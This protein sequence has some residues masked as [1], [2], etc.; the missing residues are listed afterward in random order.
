MA[1]KKTQV[2]YRDFTRG[3]ITEANPL[4]FP[5]NASLDEQNMNINRDGSRQRR[6]GMDWSDAAHEIALADSLSS[7]GDAV[8]SFSWKSVGNNGEVNLGVV[9]RGLKLYFYDLNLPDPS[10]SLLYTHTFTPLE[11]PSAA[12][13]IHFSSAYGKLIMAVGTQIVYVGTWNG[14]SLDTPLDSYSLEVR[15]RWGVD[16]G[17]A[18]DFRPPTLSVAHE[19]N[20]RNQGWPLVTWVVNP[21]GDGSVAPSYLD[22]LATTPANFFIITGAL[23]YPSNADLF[24]AAKMAVILPTSTQVNNINAHSTWELSKLNFGTTPAPRGHYIID[25]FSRGASRIAVSGIIGLPADQSFGYVNSV[26]SYA[27]RIWHSVVSTIGTQLGDFSPNIGNMLFYSIASS[28]ID[29]W[30]K[31]HAEGDPSSEESNDPIDT[32]GGFVTLTEAG[33]IFKMIPMGESLFVFA[34]NGVWEIFGGDQGFSATIQSVVKVTDIGPLSEKTIV[35]GENVIA[36]WAETGIIAISISPTTLRGTPINITEETI[37]SYYDDIL[38]DFKLEAKGEYDRISKQ[39]LWL[40]NTVEQESKYYFTKELVLD[41]NKQAFSKREIIPVS[42]TLGIGPYPTAHLKMQNIII[43][44]V[45]EDVTVGGVPVTAGGETVTIIISSSEQKTKTSLLYFIANTD[46]I[47]EDYYLGS[48]INFNFIDWERIQGALGDFGKDTPAYLLTGYTTGGDSSRDKWAPYVSVKFKR[49][50]SGY[51][52][53]PVTHEI[54]L[55]DESSCT[56]QGQWQWTNDP[57]VGRWTTPQQAYRLPRFFT[58]SPEHIFAHDV[59][60]TRNKIRGKGKALSI[61]FSSEPGKDMY[62]YGW[63]MDVAMKTTASN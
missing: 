5:E 44:T 49:T 58:L 40:Y 34:T 10:S 18:V 48:Y 33:R 62:I 35:D 1:R 9:Q 11:M 52:E 21:P 57:V 3:F 45:P 59:I 55:F 25:P 2:E 13:P 24:W 43:G 51:V 54:T 15:D 4:E 16:D 22:P 60:S 38:I 17:L 14:S 6:F 8:S 20:L 47:A 63:G 50:E 30:N 37:Q 32:D 39:I 42:K 7:T 46:G 28:D 41:L 27:G 26:A 19:Y 53:N 12:V 29:K 61:K 31:C 23:A 56:L 36:Y